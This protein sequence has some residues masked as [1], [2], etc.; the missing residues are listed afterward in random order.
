MISNFP[1]LN[2]ASYTP[3]A[4]YVVGRRVSRRELH[5]VCTIA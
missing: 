4:K 1:K 3:N 2:L 5:R